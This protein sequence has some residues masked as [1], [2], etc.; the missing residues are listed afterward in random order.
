LFYWRYKPNQRINLK[1]EQMRHAQKCAL[2]SG[3]WPGKSNALSLPA[4]KMHAALLFMQNKR[5][6]AAGE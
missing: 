2:L 3:A 1:P 5:A 6:R 4:A